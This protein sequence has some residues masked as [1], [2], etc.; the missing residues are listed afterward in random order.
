MAEAQP[1]EQPEETITLRINW[2]AADDVPVYVGNQFMLQFTPEGY[3]LSIGQVLPPGIIG[4][5]PE[6]ISAMSEFP[7][8]VLGRVAMTPER[9]RAL[10]LLLRRQLA[11]F[12][13]HLSQEVPT[14]TETEQP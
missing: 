4:A 8:N 5:T 7:V 2:R 13:P 1:Q 6:E 3:V 10:M 11:R 9:T 14:E 12:S